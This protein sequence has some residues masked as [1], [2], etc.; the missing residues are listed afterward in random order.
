MKPVRWYIRHATLQL[1]LAATFSLAAQA[2]ELSHARIVRLSFAEGVVSVHRPDVEEWATASVNTPIQEGFKVATDEGGFAEIEFENAST[3]RIGQGSVLEFTQLA[4]LPSGGKLNRMNLA[5]GYASF[6]VRPETD[7][8][9][10]VTAGNA[11][12]TPHGKSLFRVDL[13]GNAFLVKVFKGSVEIMSPEGN[14]TLGKN[15]VLAIRPGDEQSFEISYGVQKDEWDEWVENREE[16]TEMVR[17]MG[18]NRAFSGYSNNTSD[19]LWGAMDLMYFG[20]WIND[21]T[22]GYGWMP[23]V[24]PGWSPYTRGRWSWYPGMGYTW[25]GYEPWGWLPYHYGSWTFNQGIGWCWYPTGGFGAWSPALVS[26]YQG[27]GWVGWSPR[28]AGFHESCP[29]SQGCVAT[30]PNGFLA[31]G[32]VIEPTQ[33][34]WRSPF[35]SGRPL[36]RLSLEPGPSALL[37]GMGRDASRGFG[38]QP[39]DQ[40]S[41][42][43]QTDGGIAVIGGVREGRSSSGAPGITFDSASG[44][45]VNNSAST[46]AS[47]QVAPNS[48]EFAREHSQAGSTA[49]SRPAPTNNYPVYPA[50][51]GRQ[52]GVAPRSDGARESSGSDNSDWIRSNA[53][54]WGIPRNESSSSGSSSNGSRGSTANTD[55]PSS[56]S[57]SP[58]ASGGGR[59]SGGNSGGWGGSGSS[60]GSRGS[61]GS[62]SNNSGGG[63]GGN[64][65]SVGG[66]GNSGG[67]WGGGGGS[68]GNVG[69]GGGGAAGGHPTGG[70]GGGRA[71]R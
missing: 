7:D 12:L 53:V 18:V 31:D 36:D 52:T 69:G 65:G 47:P 29:R 56:G 19:L 26:W 3:A 6:S 45:Y 48:V 59:P 22:Y 42:G 16:R 17:N 4:L 50:S 27:D 61:A 68:R 10:E 40:Q 57:S 20:T 63:G 58:A 38:R 54:G 14:G 41:S 28:G 8:V 44:R 70:G 67:G 9:Y 2:E 15:S 24:G 60:G 21:P 5:Q 13:E 37:P 39:A 49:S 66:G 11:T 34:Q 33:V 46:P 62:P 64:R 55:R 35:E 32:R 1:C 25:I 23:T 71:P 30:M 51:G 43:V